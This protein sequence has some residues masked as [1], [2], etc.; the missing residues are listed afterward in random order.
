MQKRDRT[1]GQRTRLLWRWR[2]VQISRFQ[3]PDL[4]VVREPDTFLRVS[5]PTAGASHA[6][7]NWRLAQSIANADN[8]EGDFKGYQAAAPM[9]L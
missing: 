9:H 8:H 6:S 2:I 4:K 1:P 5:M 3:N 7:T